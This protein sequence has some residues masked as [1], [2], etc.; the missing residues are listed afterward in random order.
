MRVDR[1]DLRYHSALRDRVLDLRSGHQGLHL[2]FGPN[3]AGKSS[4]RRALADALLGFEHSTRAA[5]AGQRE[6]SKLRVGATLRHSDGRVVE[7]VRRKNNELWDGHDQRLID[8]D[9]L[10]DFVIVANRARHEALF[11]LDHARLREGGNS[12][13]GSGELTSSAVAA[14]GLGI[15]RIETELAALDKTARD[16][17]LPRGSRSEVR[18]LDAEIQLA[19]KQVEERCLSAER[20]EMLIRELDE[21]HRNEAHAAA[22]WSQHNEAT[23]EIDRLLRYR[24]IL[25][26][27][28]F[29]LGRIPAAV[30][31][32]R[33]AAAAAAAWR[34]LASAIDEQQAQLKAAERSL[35][36]LRTQ[37][38]GLVA[39][40][41]VR[42]HRD[43]IA[44]SQRLIPAVGS[45]LTMEIESDRSKAAACNRRLIEL[46]AANDIAEPSIDEFIADAIRRR[47]DLLP[48]VVEAQKLLASHREKAANLR[49]VEREI[50]V[51][52]EQAAAD[53]S[54]AR[55]AYSYAGTLEDWLAIVLPRRET[56]AEFERRATAAQTA[57]A[58]TRHERETKRDELERRRRTLVERETARALPTE[59]DLDEARG[60]RDAL[61]EKLRGDGV[62][63]DSVLSRLLAAIREADRI[64][65]VIRNEATEVA[66]R[67]AGRA[68]V[69]DAQRNVEELDARE[70]R[71]QA[72]LDNLR[73]EH[74]ALWRELGMS[75]RWPP[76]EMV[77]ALEVRERIAEALEAADAH[78]RTLLRDRELV[79]T[80]IA[81]ASR[82]LGE[83][84]PPELELESAD[85]LLGTL[86]T[87]VGSAAQLADRLLAIR[88][89]RDNAE[90]SADASEQTVR[91]FL[92]SV[93]VAV[94][95]CGSGRVPA[96]LADGIVS[97]E[98][99]ANELRAAD[100]VA[101]Q[102]DV[103]DSQIRR[104]ETVVAEHSAALETS[105]T[106][107]S[108]VLH[109]L[110]IATE[111][112][113]ESL[114]NDLVEVLSI[115]Q[116]LSDD[117]ESIESL[118]TIQAKYDHVDLEV[119]RARLAEARERAREDHRRTIE[120]RA[121]CELV[122][123][124][125]DESRPAIDELQAVSILRSRRAR[126]TRN[127]L[128]H[129]I[130]HEMLVQGLRSFRERHETRVRAHATAIFSDLTLSRYNELPDSPDALSEGTADQLYLALVLG[131]LRERFET[132]EP[133]PVVL[134]DV[135]VHFDDERSEAALKALARFSSSAQVLLFTHHA[136]IREFALSL[137]DAGLDIHVHDLSNVVP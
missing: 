10:A 112:D 98:R 44:K 16:L 122:L 113:P 15:E 29:L 27:R 55:S 33:D 97:T 49:D 114:A 32:P 53:F 8:R 38:V 128:R 130:A 68:E 119:E 63:S 35:A 136:R 14:A 41:G 82:V 77:T 61:V 137:A 133:Q 31:L 121:T 85:Q 9:A 58:R 103:L 134:D 120:Q 111:P 109:R 1:L 19:M 99:L 83:A 105:R 79:A 102:R 104:A 46:A 125:F 64:A 6:Y 81:A 57:V 28:S 65:D 2:I 26:R 89:E 84:Q 117:D 135:L 127:Y 91:R 110:G 86:S 78:R 90:R 96:D 73:R 48:Q 50:L 129:R 62:P 72:S 37:L 95:A 124:Q 11:S 5:F 22:T 36:D 13:L 18:R 66:L 74:L 88:E 51:L 101:S 100:H 39:N 12:L 131:S 30:T 92:D 24:K 45:Q 23:S 118:M 93:K 7:F 52:Q 54:I 25:Q 107:R 106:K 87:K 17:Y 60:V 21:A 20:R 67:A 76:S 40:D 69:R 34:A 56:I 126:A 108:Q 75:P 116:S 115:D 43:V 4:I 47:D 123:R 80:A 42:R 132:E 3:E 94:E 70:L 71:E 59:S